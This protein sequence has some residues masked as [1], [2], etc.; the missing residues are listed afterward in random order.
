MLV[1]SPL[2]TLWRKTPHLPPPP[3]QSDW[4][5]CASKSK[6]LTETVKAL[7]PTGER[8]ATTLEKSNITGNQL[9]QSEETRSVASAPLS[10]ASA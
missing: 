5:R 4:R 1:V 6:H 8:S 7:Q 2:T 9:P 3:P 10:Y